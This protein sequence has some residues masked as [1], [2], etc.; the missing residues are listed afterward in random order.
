MEKARRAYAF[1]LAGDRATY[2]IERHLSR[3]YLA[4]TIQERSVSL[5]D[6]SERLDREYIPRVDMTTI[7]RV[8]RSDQ[9]GRPTKSAPIVYR[10]GAVVARAYAAAISAEGSALVDAVAH[11]WVAHVASRGGCGD[12][13]L[14]PTM[15][16]KRRSTPRQRRYG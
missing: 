6:G 2:R 16:W 1:E 8:A 3:C 7:L 11:T 5:A 9:A 15:R 12:R 14:A 4:H 13:G 10:E